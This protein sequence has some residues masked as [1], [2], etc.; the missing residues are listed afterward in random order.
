MALVK[1]E[2][3]GIA[4]KIV[5]NMTAESWETIP[6]AML[7]YNAD[8]TELFKE[9]KKLNADC[10]DK[11]KKITINTVMLK[12]ICEGYKAAPKM[13]THLEFNRKLVRG[14]LKYFDHIDISM[15]MVLPSGEM[16]TINISRLKVL[17]V[18]LAIQEI[19]FDFEND[20]RSKNTSEEREKIAQ[21]SID[22][23]WKPLLEEI[24][25]QFEE[26]DK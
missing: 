9:C 3:F 12:I 4:R 18:E 19:I 16:M 6:H 21:S 5:S 8:V 1:K 24:K 17:D 15:P 2:R 20:I 14:T 26:Q 11:S 7:V 25:K 13:N 10:T 23:R 22:R